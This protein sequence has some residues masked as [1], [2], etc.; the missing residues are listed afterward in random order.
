MHVLDPDGESIRLAFAIGRK[1]GSAVVRNRL[2]RRIRHIMCELTRA[3][4]ITAPTGSYLFI[5][6]QGIDQLTFAE[7]EVTVTDVVEALA[8]RDL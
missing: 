2:R 3:D 4:A 8:A 6:G 1:V 7:L 5:A